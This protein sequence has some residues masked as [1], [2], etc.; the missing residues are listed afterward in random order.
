MPAEPLVYQLAEY[1]QIEAGLSDGQA[2]QLQAAAGSRLTL[3]P[4]SRGYLIRA[5]SHVGS[6]AVPG[7]VLH[8]LPKVPVVNILH[9]MT[10]STERISLGRDEPD[11]ATGSLT[12]AVAAWYSRML[13]RTLV[14]GVDRSYVE[15]ADRVVALRGRI[16]WPAQTRAVGLPTPIACRYDEWS[17]DTRANR[18]VAAAAL[19]LLRNPAVP[20]QP[21]FTLRRLLR[22]LA[23]VGPLRPD[24]LSAQHDFLTRLNEHYRTT[25]QLARLVLH[26]GGLAQGAGH[27][28]V[29]SFM[30]NMNDVFED[31][32][33]ASLKQR[34]RGTWEVDKRKVPL[35]IAGHMPTEPDLLFTDRLGANALVADSK[36][37]LTSDGRGRNADYYQLLA[38]CTSLGL[39]RGVLIYCDT[40]GNGPTPPRSIQVREARTVL[41][42]FRVRLAGSF[43]DIASEF[44]RLAQHLRGR[45]DGWSQAAAR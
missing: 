19:A 16:D 24:D 41:E 23:G 22:L 9:L 27:A 30:V 8:V 20:P 10:W 40:D 6:I 13:E 32:V 7:I 45:A 28:A 29:S 17:L 12:A 14:L 34:L 26:A 35:D 11:Q 44:D 15:E 21:A 5:S 3:T 42:T 18:I 2:R 1:Q 37:K 31:Y 4:S 36:Y 25:V 38:Y 39:R 33:F 43:D